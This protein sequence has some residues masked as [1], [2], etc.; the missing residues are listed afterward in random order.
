M[1]PR[2]PRQDLIEELRALAPDARR[3][4]AAD[5]L[6]ADPHAL[7]GHAPSDLAELLG[8]PN[9]ARPGASWSVTKPPPIERLEEHT[10]GGRVFETLWPF[11]REDW[12]GDRRAKLEREFKRCDDE[13][14]QD[15]GFLTAGERE[16]LTRELVR[17]RNA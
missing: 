12:T 14:T 7:R 11:V 6:E 1:A 13:R 4:R 15:F 17:M 8:V 16:A 10:F 3:L 5:A 2:I 9:A